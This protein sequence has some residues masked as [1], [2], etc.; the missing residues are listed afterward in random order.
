MARVSVFLESARVRGDIKESFA[1][2]PIVRILIARDMAFVLRMA[3]VYAK[4]DGRVS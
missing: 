3:F 1:K 4:R 2:R